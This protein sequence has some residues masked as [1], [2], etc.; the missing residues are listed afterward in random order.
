M[1]DLRR[2][3]WW[4]SISWAAEPG[5]WGLG[6]PGRT[7]VVC[8]LLATTCKPRLGHLG[9][10]N[11]SDIAFTRPVVHVARRVDPTPPML[12][13]TEMEESPAR[14]AIA[15]AYI[16][17]SPPPARAPDSRHRSPLRS[18]TSQPAPLLSPL[19]YFERIQSAVVTVL[20]SIHYRDAHGKDPPPTHAFELCIRRSVEEPGQ[21]ARLLVDRPGTNQG[22]TMAQHPVASADNQASDLV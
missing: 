4:H 20:Y 14:L 7:G 18:H 5:F 13:I 6:T 21:F 11:K 3:H 12:P 10:G 22:G 8:R 1:D 15:P 9:E 2:T 17:P 19:G 16:D